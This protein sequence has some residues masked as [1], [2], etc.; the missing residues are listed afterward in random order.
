MQAI[1]A[2]TATYNLGLAG[3]RFNNAPPDDQ[4]AEWISIHSAIKAAESIGGKAFDIRYDGSR[5]R[6]MWV[7]FDDLDSHTVIG[8]DGDGFSVRDEPPSIYPNKWV[9]KDE[10][11]RQVEPR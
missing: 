7:Y 6:T 11:A 5:I 2:K 3:E 4:A 8:W 10:L 1:E 9:S